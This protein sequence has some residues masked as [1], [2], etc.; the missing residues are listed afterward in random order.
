[1]SFSEIKSDCF[2]LLYHFYLLVAEIVKTLIALIICLLLILSKLLIILFPH[3]IKLWKTVYE[4]HKTLSLYDLVLEFSIISIVL[5]SYLFRRQIQNSWNQFERSVSAK[6]KAVARAAPHIM[7][8]SAALIIAVLGRKFILP[9]T[10]TSTM[11]VFTLVIP[12]GN[13]LWLLRK[14]MNLSDSAQVEKYA[15]CLV[16]LVVLGI[17]HSLVTWLSLIPFS[18]MFLSYLPYLKELVLVILLWIHISSVFSS[19]VFDSIISPVMSRLSMYIPTAKHGLPNQGQFS[20][21]NS[22]AVLQDFE[23]KQKQKTNMLI[24]LLKMMRLLN[25]HQIN[26]ISLILQDSVVSIMGVLFIFTP[27]PFSFMGM[28]LIAFVLPSY[29]TVN[30]VYNL[31][32]HR[33]TIGTARSERAEMNTATARSIHALRKSLRQWIYYWVCVIIIWLTRIYFFNPWTSFVIISTLWLQHSFFMG[34]TKTVDNIC[35]TFHLLVERN[36]TIQREKSEKLGDSPR[37]LSDSASTSNSNLNLIRNDSSEAISANEA[38]GI[39]SKSNDD[40][41]IEDDSSPVDAASTRPKL[42]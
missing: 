10:S 6:S 3:A 41:P 32:R 22:E 26:I 7:F 27:F 11:P 39:E 4:F 21:H 5:V 9:L 8:F 16:I 28:V 37:R 14:P 17:Y 20:T 1:M 19:I 24:N 38:G 15:H 36:E 13:T 29:R 40:V 35:D 25:D 23:E 31:H 18:K 12:L 33:T 42:E 30:L 34:A 2:S